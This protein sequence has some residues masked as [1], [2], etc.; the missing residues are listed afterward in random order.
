MHFQITIVGVGLAGQQ[1]FQ[2]GRVGPAFQGVQHGFRFGHDVAVVLG[3]AQFDQL[4]AV[5]QFALDVVDVLDP[6]LKAVALAHQGL[7]L[8]GIIPQFGIFRLGVQFLELEDGIVVV[9][10][11]SSAVPMTARRLKDALNFS[12]HGGG[13]LFSVVVGRGL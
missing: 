8:V 1:G 5:A 13:L 7:G 6:A 9:K 12:A 10:D 11:A 2:L 4:D 3:L